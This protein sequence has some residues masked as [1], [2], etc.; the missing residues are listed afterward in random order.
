VHFHYTPKHASWT[1]QIEI[2]FSILTG[3]SLKGALFTS[4]ATLKDHIDSF[5]ASYNQDAKLLV[6]TKSVF[7]QNQL[8]LCFAA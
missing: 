7:H 2:W 3:K 8:K 4:V 6:W 1:N 5:I